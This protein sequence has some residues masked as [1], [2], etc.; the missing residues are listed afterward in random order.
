MEI[1]CAFLDQL[2]CHV[3]SAF[4]G[5]Q[6]VDMFKASP[7]GKYHMIFMDVMMPVMDGLEATHLIRTSGHPDSSTIP[8]I[9]VSAN[10][11]DEDIKRSLSSGMTVHLSKPIEPQKL[12][13]TV[14][15][16]AYGRIEK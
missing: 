10:A 5:Q 2:G 7:K 12:Q 9:A 14:R 4:N 15:K 16:F 1:I 6:A 3:D 13:Q 8:V 11:F